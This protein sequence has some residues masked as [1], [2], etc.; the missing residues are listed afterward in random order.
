MIYFPV[1]APLF[2]TYTPIT[3]GVLYER[4]QALSKQVGYHSKQAYLVDGSKRSGHSNAYFFGMMC[5]KRMVI[6]DTLLKSE[7][8][9]ETDMD[10]VMATCAHEIS[11]WKHSH[12]WKLF[13]LQSVLFFGIFY[14]FGLFL[15]TTQLYS[16][17]AFQDRPV[18]IGLLLF[19]QIYAPLDKL[20]DFGIHF[21]SR[22][23]EYEA[24]R[25]ALALGYDIKN[26]LIQVYADNKAS[27]HVDP[28]FSIA[29]H[30]HPTLLE[31]IAAIDKLQRK[32][33]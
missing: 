20:S 13:M 23:F 2:N 1:I 31:R 25:G 15:H 22:A 19:L 28:L 7:D 30:T 26:A 24:D 6:Y 9:K 29:N 14:L 17:F 18:L 12:T 27:P 4:L 3:E 32:S 11:H 33:K 10:D 5:F 21:V 8:G 16:A